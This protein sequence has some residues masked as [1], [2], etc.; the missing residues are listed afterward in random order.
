MRGRRDDLRDVFWDE[1]S[2]RVCA[3]EQADVVT[4][5]RLAPH[6]EPLVDLDVVAAR[7]AERPACMGRRGVARPVGC[8]RRDAVDLEERCP[9]RVDVDFVVA[10]QQRAVEVEEDEEAQAATGASSALRR[11]PTYS[12]SAAGPSSATSTARDPTTTPSA[13][14]AA[15]WAWAGVEIPKPA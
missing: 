11:E 10:E 9:V 2:R 3:R 8:L 13:S 14:S 1:P 5:H 15:A 12:R 4:G 7:Q 6:L